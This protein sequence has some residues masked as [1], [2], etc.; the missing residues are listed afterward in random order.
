MWGNLLLICAISILLTF[1]L[2]G[3]SIAVLRFVV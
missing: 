2:K 3:G 1:K